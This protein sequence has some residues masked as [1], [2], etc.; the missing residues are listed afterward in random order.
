VSTHLA[1]G[2]R[3]REA[4][5]EQGGGAVAAVLWQ[6]R[7]AGARITG[8]Q[9]SSSSAAGRC[10]ARPGWA[11]LQSARSCGTRLSSHP[12]ETHAQQWGAA[13]LTVQSRR[14]HGAQLA[15]L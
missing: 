9:L 14:S 6:V 2:A 5:A 12:P 7:C 10:G 15:R 1:A 13:C 11:L 4:S 3:A 8:V